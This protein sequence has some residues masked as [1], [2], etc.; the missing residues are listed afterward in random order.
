M[1]SCGSGSSPPRR[2]IE[3]FLELPAQPSFGHL[4]FVMV[5]AW[6]RRPAADGDRP[7]WRRASLS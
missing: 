1:P 2:E 4:P 3:R 6:G 7:S 5:T